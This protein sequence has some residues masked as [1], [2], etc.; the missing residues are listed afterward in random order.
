MAIGRWSRYLPT[1]DE[2]DSRLV[3][4]RL[5]LDRVQPFELVWEPYRTAEVADI[6]HP[7]IFEQRHAQL[8]TARVP[9]IYYSTIEW[10]QVDR[11]IPQFVGVPYG[12]PEH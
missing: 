4:F 10:N 11:I 12:A 8:W 2:K 9:L 7:A 5:F 1:S 6:A 3:Q